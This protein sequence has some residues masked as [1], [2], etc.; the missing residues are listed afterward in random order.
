M[1]YMIADT[2]NKV[3]FRPYGQTNPFGAAHL[4]GVPADAG[5]LGEYY[6]NR[7]FDPWELYTDVHHTDHKLS[8]L[9][10]F[11]ELGQ[12]HPFKS[13]AWHL[14]GLGAASDP[15]GEAADELLAA[16]H[17]TQ[18]EHDAILEG[19]MSFQ[20]VLGY[21]P[22][23][24]SSWANLVS[25]FQEVN[26]DLQTLEH[27]AQ[28]VPGVAAAVGR[29]L[30]AKRQQ[31]SDLATQFTRY[32]TLLMGSAPAGISGLGIAPL[33]WVAGA[34]V[35]I[36]G[37]FITL[38]AIH[39]W[40]KSVD[41]NAIQANATQTQTQSTAS[42]NKDLL[43]ALAAAQA[44]GDTVTAQAILKT[45]ASTGAQPQSASTLETWLMTNAKWIGL[46]AVALVMAGPLASGLFG[47]K[48]R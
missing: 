4:S 1:A 47:G 18:A 30:I 39:T 28:T 14:H 26:Q 13:Q 33:V 40:S 27:Q 3:G 7:P 31:Y 37:A 12:N 9:G 32:Y 25:L 44:K 8:G 24:S 5:G 21:D 34:A 22:T 29:D 36:V 23:D 11:G 35:F 16:G 6:L 46:G 2:G 19:S 17:I 42:T 10:E 38:Y 20:D 41:V 43:S 45:L 48:R 15:T